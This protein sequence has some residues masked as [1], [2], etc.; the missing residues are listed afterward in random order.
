MITIIEDS[1]QQRGQHDLKSAYFKSAG[2][3]VIRSKVVAGD[4]V[5]LND[6][7]RTVDTK[8]GLNEIVNNLVHDHERF[9]READFCKDNGIEFIVLIEEPGMHCLEDV[10]KWENPRLRRYNKINYM[11]SI[12]KWQTVPEPKGKP[13]TNNITLYKIMW[14]FAQN[15]A[16]RFEFCAPKDAGRRIIELLTEGKRG[17]NT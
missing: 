9:R 11:H 8:K 2:I 3:K 15:H 4:Y 13:P 14:T 10:K 12:G 7:S 5:L 17:L 1:R 16:T 6:M